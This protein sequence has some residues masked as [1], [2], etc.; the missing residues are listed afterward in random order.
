MSRDLV[1][2]YGMDGQFMLM[3]YLWKQK[4]LDKTL[5]PL[6]GYIINIITKTKDPECK[7]LRI[8]LNEEDVVRFAKTLRPVAVEVEARMRSPHKTDAERWP[9]NFAVCKSP[10]GYGIC[11]FWDLCSSHGK[12]IDMYEVSPWG[13]PKRSKKLTVLV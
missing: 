4:N 10:K 11:N 7:R 2:G 9:M 3:Y 8:T 1:E 5:G 6:R 12:L 13:A